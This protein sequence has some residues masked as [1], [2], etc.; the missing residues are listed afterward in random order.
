VLWSGGSRR[1]VSDG[2]GP[3][4]RAPRTVARALEALDLSHLRR[5]GMLGCP[6]GSAS[7]RILPVRLPGSTLSLLDE[8]TAHL[9]LRHQIQ[10]LEILKGAARE[11]RKGFCWCC[12]T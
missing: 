11:Q 1:P 5:R 4:Y 3:G 10:T 9:D 12:T 2:A 8:P 7:A 6:T